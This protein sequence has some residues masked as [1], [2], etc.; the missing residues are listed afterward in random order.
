MTFHQFV[1]VRFTG[2]LSAYSVGDPTQFTGCDL[3]IPGAMFGEVTNYQDL[4]GNYSA[5]VSIAIAA[6]LAAAA[7]THVSG[8]VYPGTGASYICSANT[9]FVDP[10]YRSDYSALQA[11][12]Y[13]DI[14]VQAGIATFGG[15]SVDYLAPS[16][17]VF[18]RSYDGTAWIFNQ[19]QNRK[20]VTVST[21]TL[22]LTQA[23]NGKTLN[24]TV[25]CTVTT[26]SSAVILHPFRCDMILTGMC[27]SLQ[28]LPG[29]G[30]TLNS[31]N[32]YRKVLTKYARASME[33]YLAHTYNLDSPNLSA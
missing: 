31:A 32:N 2:A 25:N 33:T 20:V 7:P 27:T 15:G 17:M 9:Y 18:R 6:A 10:S 23:H 16:S 28:V 13:Y 5:P 29:T 8:T 21:S 26:P 30:D 12:D 19:A 14:T 3:T 24:F 4:G 1:G 11:G 22:V